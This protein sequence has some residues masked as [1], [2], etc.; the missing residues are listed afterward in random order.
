[1]DT[2]DISQFDFVLEP[3][4][5]QQLFTFSP[6][7]IAAFVDI[8]IVFVDYVDHVAINPHMTNL[9]QVVVKLVSSNETAAL[10]RSLTKLVK[11][12]VRV[13]PLMITKDLFNAI[14]LFFCDI[15]NVA[16]DDGM[17]DVLLYLFQEKE[18][19][20]SIEFKAYS[21]LLARLEAL[22]TNLMNA[23]AKELLEIL[24]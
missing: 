3:L 2:D 1:L 21:K 20:P 13:L 24:V 4:S 18:E 17:L 10:I 16:S 12:M 5:S 15:K 14:I 11:K 6:N 22:V 7:T 9:P 23:K 8:L 19:I